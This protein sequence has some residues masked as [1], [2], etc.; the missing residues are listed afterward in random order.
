VHHETQEYFQQERRRIAIVTLGW[1]TQATI[2]DK[3]A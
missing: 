2:L 1:V 3:R